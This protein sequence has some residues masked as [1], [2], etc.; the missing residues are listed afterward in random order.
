MLGGNGRPDIQGTRDLIFEYVETHPGT[1]LREIGRALGLGMGDLQ[2]NLYILEKQGKVSTARR[3]LYKFVF[4]SGV[5]GE[6]QSAILSAL[7]IE[8]QR[9]ILIHLIKNPALSQ[10]QIAR[11]I[12]LTPA[13]ISWHMKRLLELGIVERVRNG[14]TV[15]YRVLGDKEEIEKFVR[16]YH[17][18]FWERLSSKLADIILELSANDL[19][20]K[21]NN[22]H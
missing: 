16:S 17:P 22:S 3:G 20:K 15:S 6:K 14:K 10:N 2:Y 1:H 18:G 4:P 11:L 9:E 7:A 19:T 8:S 12:G 21:E 13:T 5:F